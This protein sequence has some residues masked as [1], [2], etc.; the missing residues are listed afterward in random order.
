MEDFFS[1]G[2]MAPLASSLSFQTWSRR[3]SERAQA[4][5]NGASLLP[6][7]RDR[8][9]AAAD[10]EYWGMADMPNTYGDVATLDFD[11][12]SDE[13]GLLLG[14][15]CHTPLQTEVLDVLLAALL[16]SYRNATAADGRTGAPTIYNEGHGREAWDSTIDLSRT[17]GWFT[18]LCPVHLPNESSSG[19]LLAILHLI[20]IFLPF[21][22]CSHLV[23]YLC[24]QTQ[25]GDRLS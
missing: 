10:V 1:T 18:T 8:G 5:T 21:L 25:R 7:H 3:Q 16:L 17:V 19:M 11:L 4:Q 22:S 15:E 2:H 6:H 24:C 12:D 23:L 14:P 9:C 20:P 13:T